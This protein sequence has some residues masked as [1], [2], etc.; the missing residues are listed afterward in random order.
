MSNLITESETM[1]SQRLRFVSAGLTWTVAFVASFVG[2]AVSLG[3]GLIGVGASLII[4]VGAAST[5]YIVWPSLS[6]QSSPLVQQAT[7]L[8]DT[9]KIVRPIP[10]NAN[11][12]SLD[13]KRVC[14]IGPYRVKPGSYTKIPLDVG[15][16]DNIGGLLL[17]KDNWDFDYRIVDETNLVRYVNE[18]PKL[19]PI[20]EGDHQPAYDVKCIVPHVGPWYLVLDL[21]ARQT[22]R[23]VEVNLYKA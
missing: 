14:G 8:S 13:R 1:D 18:D 21:Y 3:G 11:T 2:L 19:D 10:S 22:F 15:A 9:P 6:K 5:L 12:T 17:E 20:D 23:D 16:G 7:F 4:A